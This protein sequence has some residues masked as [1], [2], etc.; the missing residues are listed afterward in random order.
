M[1]ELPFS[2]AFATAWQE[3][4]TYRKEEKRLRPY[5]EKGLKRTI[6]YLIN[7]ANND[8]EKAIEIINY[9]M[10]QQ[11]QGLFLPKKNY[12]T[13]NNKTAGANDLYAQVTSYFKQGE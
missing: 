1:N 11:Y 2:E 9:S 13:N 12:A 10:N 5:T 3:W 8:E 7:L 4:L 6:T